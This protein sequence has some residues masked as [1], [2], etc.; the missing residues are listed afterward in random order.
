MEDPRAVVVAPRDIEVGGTAY[1][2]MAFVPAAEA[3]SDVFTA[4]Q[5]VFGRV[6]TVPIGKGQVITADMLEPPTE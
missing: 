5:D 1:A 3:G 2:I 6:A 4:T